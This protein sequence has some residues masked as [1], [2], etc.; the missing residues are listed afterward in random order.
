MIQ[1]HVVHFRVLCY[2]SCEMKVI[3]SKDFCMMR[4]ILGSERK[5]VWLKYTEQ[6]KM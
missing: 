3:D 5:P 6:G 4:H 2:V 1:V